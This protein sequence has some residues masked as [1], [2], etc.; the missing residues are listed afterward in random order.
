MNVPSDRSFAEQQDRAD[1]LAKMRDAFRIPTRADG[2]EHVYFCGHSL[3]L[4]PKAVGRV[5]Q[6][7]L[8]S[9]AQ[10]AVD[11]HFES[12]R[13]WLSYHERFAP[14]LAK[15]VGAQP[16]EVVAMNTLT[17]N[18]HLMLATFY[19]PT[20]E[21]SKILV[22]KHAFSSD[23]YAVA[24]QA[25]L[26]GFDPQTAMLEIGPRPG[27]EAVR[28][29]DVLSLIEREGAQIATVMLPG[30]QFLNGQRFDLHAITQ[31][32]QR[33]GCRV[34]F[35]LAHAIGNVPL[36]LH[37]S[38][39]DFAVWCHYKYLNAGPGAVGG[40]FVHERHA[41]DF[42]LV[43]LA[44]WWGHDKASRFAMPHEFRPLPGAEGWQIS[45]L[46]ILA[47][48]P[49]LASLPLFDAA[50]VPALRAKSLQLTGY[51]ESLLR[52]QLADSVTILTPA[53]PEARGCQLSLRLRRSSS[54]AHKVFDALAAAGFTGDWREP[55]V[56]RVAPVPLYNTFTEVWEFAA[57]LGR[58]LR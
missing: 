29:E 31:A 55:D 40:C 42:D 13:P 7:E 33:A 34:G 3:G 51:L 6:E 28:T 10:R 41:R 15:L 17:V 44:G 20:R 4:Q 19:R 52:A 26:H 50:G 58:F 32:G 25:R 53:D 12:S 39:A 38:G 5:V 1:P 18:L 35:D 46:P 16:L 37:D 11:G 54:D 56:I 43:R 36:A 45:N 24:S 9:W 14:S 47:A 48:A 30:I 49:L 2:T 27:E 8:D 22:E 21:R 23:R 57:T